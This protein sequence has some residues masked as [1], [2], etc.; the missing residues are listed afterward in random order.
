MTK[1]RSFLLIML[2]TA[3]IFSVFSTL[4]VK[5]QLSSFSS[6]QS[7]A[8]YRTENYSNGDQYTGYFV[9]GQYN[10]EGTY[11][12]ANGDRYEGEFMNGQIDGAGRLTFFGNGQY[13]EGLFVQGKISNGSGIFYWGSNG[14][15]FD[16][17]WLNGQPEGTGILLHTNGTSE[18]VTFSNG[19]LIGQ[20]GSTAGG[21][22]WPSG[23][24]G[25]YSG[26]ANSY[27]FNNIKVGDVVNFGRYEQDNN[28]N[29]GSEPIQWRVLDI[30]YTSGKALLLSVYGLETM[31]YHW[32]AAPVTWENCSLRQYLNSNFYKGVF[33]D[34]ERSQIAQTRI[35]NPP[36]P[37]YGTYGGNDTFDYVFL[38]SINEIRYYFPSEGS[39]KASPTQLARAHGAYGTA[40]VNCAWWWL[41]SPGQKTNCASSINSIGVLLDTGPVVSDVTGM[42][43]PAIW[44]NL[45]G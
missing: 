28:Y 37:S 11:V 8:E 13:W 35:S 14:D 31:A 44:V 33:S 30:D 42:I 25:Q 36:S 34:T 10:G 7:A 27:A 29:N 24:Q 39:R 12:W 32:D 9:N 38:L 4:S 40:D 2:F 18:K 26:G 45:A 1:R 6:G 21:N 17:Q 20:I 3:V 19:Q 16:G 22:E 41:R 23:S 43:R 15:K 5:A